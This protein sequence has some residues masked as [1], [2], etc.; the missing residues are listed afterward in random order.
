M[1]NRYDS[2]VIG[3]GFGGA[4]MACRLAEAGRSVLVLERGREWQVGDYP[5]VSRDNWIWDDGEPENQNGWMD[6][7]VF[8]RMA[9]AQGAGVGGGSLIY[10]NVSI[11]AEPE[12]IDQGWPKEIDFDTLKPFYDRA[13]EMLAVSSLPDRQLT[14]RFKLARRAAEKA[15]YGERFRKL[16]L[17]VNFDPGWNYDLDDPHNASH[18]RTA[19]N[20]HGVM[21]G[22]CTHCG[23]CVI[24]CP[25]GAKNTLDLNYLARARS[26]GAQI[27]PLHLVKRLVPLSPGYRVEFDDLT[28]G[29]RAAG[30]FDADEVY[31]AAGSLGT[32]ELLLRCRD[33]HRT[34][35]DVG[36]RLGFGWSANGDFVTPAFYP[37][38]TISPAR[39]PTVSGAISFLDGNGNGDRFFVQDGGF[40]DLDGKLLE[41]ITL[42]KGVFYRALGLLGSSILKNMRNRYPMDS[43]MPWFG[44]GVD[45]ADGQLVLGRKWLRPWA[46]KLDLKWDPAKSRSLVQSLVDMHKELSGVT[47]G[48]PLVPPSWTLLRYLITPHP[49]GGC[50]MG[51][52]PADGVVDHRGR[53]FG[54]EGLYVVDG[55]VF[56]RSVGL[57]PSRTI[58]AIA[59]YMADRRLATGTR[60]ARNT[61]P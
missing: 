39:G 41:H 27:K 21:Q 5:S 7:R 48:Q 11:E 40:P 33:Q 46:R 53:V 28:D 1:R 18:S 54:Y 55:A 60:P 10:A 45:A 52:S 38:R 51:E 59:E 22:T 43:V 20:A 58:A 31:L 19:P 23:N 42:H 26:N 2:I 15:G 17:A 32:T 36:N 29:S 9:V 44:Q 30:S 24:G 37:E 34:L 25:V 14:E 47:G 50:A 4:V 61:G 49:L 16:D 8:R 13:G 57:N 56:P 3:S 6:L 35:P 12:A